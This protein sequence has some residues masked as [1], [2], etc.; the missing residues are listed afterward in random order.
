MTSHGYTIPGIGL[1]Q[2][3]TNSQIVKK[4][5][6]YVLNHGTRQEIIPAISLEPLKPVCSSFSKPN[7]FVELDLDMLKPMLMNVHETRVLSFSGITEKYARQEKVME[8]LLSRTEELEQRG[9]NMS[10]ISELME[11][12]AIKS[13]SSLLYLNQELEKPVLDLF[14]D[15]MVDHPDLSIQSN[16]HNILFSSSNSSELNDIFSI[17]SEL[18]LSSNS[19]KWRQLSPL[20]PHFQRFDNEVLTPVTVLAPLKSPEKTRPR[21]SPKKHNTKRKAKEKR[22]LYK[23]NHLHAYE[24]LLSLMISSDHKHKTKIL[25]LQ[26]SSKDLLELLTQFSI[27]VAGTGLA[28]LFSVVYNLVSRRVPFCANKFFDTGLGLSL[29]ILSWAVNRLRGVIVG[30]NKK[31]KKPCSSLNDDEEEILMMRSVERSIKEVY[32]RAA[33]VIAVFALRFAC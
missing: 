13:S 4:N 25:S 9:F 5:M 22:D 2:D 23:R 29:V 1:L 27:S 15:I 31:A 3:L 28:V 26:R 14:K 21:P 12:E 6:T 30:V 19:T 24:S 33:T 8:F 7:H 10:L 16:G 18:N 20:I 17:A 32:Y 11:I